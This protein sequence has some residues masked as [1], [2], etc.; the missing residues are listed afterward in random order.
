MHLSTVLCCFVS[1]IK[2]DSETTEGFGISDTKDV[3]ATT[4][5]KK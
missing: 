3:P 1:I 2:P 4:V 5:R